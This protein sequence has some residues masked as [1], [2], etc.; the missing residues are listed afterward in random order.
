MQS[1]E[2]LHTDAMCEK[3]ARRAAELVQ[4]LNT[5]GDDASKLSRRFIPAARALAAFQVKNSAILNPA[6]SDLTWHVMV[7]L[8]LIVVYLLDV[9]V[10][11]SAAAHI[12]RRG[13]P[14]VP[15]GTEVIAFLARVIVPG[16]IL[17]FELLLGSLVHRFGDRASKHFNRRKQVAF[18]VFGIGVA[19]AITAI[20]LSLDLASRAAAGQND[21]AISF[22]QMVFYA[23]AGLTLIFHVVVLFLGERGAAAK[24]FVVAKLTERK[25]RRAVLKW[26]EPYEE[27]HTAFVKA[28]VVYLQTA[29]THLRA[30]GAQLP[31][32][33]FSEE[34]LEPFREHFP[35]RGLPG[36]D[37]P[38]TASPKR[39]GSW[40]GGGPDEEQG[41][42]V[43][44]MPFISGGKT[45][46]GGGY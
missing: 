2:S 1:A 36:V 4:D 28:A 9:I 3:S 40:A 34:A 12:V 23:L 32:G 11:G 41:G 17:V 38:K 30:Y 35:D 20:V 14:Y 24:D 16:L 18:V 10:F 15:I 31:F 6:A 7:G 33:P 8:G 21:S 43:I 46:A 19:G 27:A 25:L 5:L 13:L 39:S 42:E 26:Q 22:H 29:E 45:G 37:G 44:D